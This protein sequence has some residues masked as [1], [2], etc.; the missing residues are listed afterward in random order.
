MQ[1]SGFKEDII[2]HLDGHNNPIGVAYSSPVIALSR[3]CDSSKLTVPLHFH[4]RIKVAEKVIAQSV[5]LHAT[6]PPPPIMQKI[7]FDILTP[8]GKVDPTK[9]PPPP[10]QTFL[11]KY[12]SKYS[13]ILY[14]HYYYLIFIFDL[15]LQWYIVLALVI[16]MFLGNVKEEAKKDVKKKE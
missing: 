1:K 15:F 8:D 2:L 13:S 9:Q 3:P 7:N 10:P 14:Y 6:G 5:S 4:T 11:Q 16:Y 12:V